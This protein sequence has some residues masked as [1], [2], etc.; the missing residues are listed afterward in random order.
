MN[1]K[2][3]FCLHRDRD[4]K[5]CKNCVSFSVHGSSDNF[6]KD[7]TV[8]T[9]EQRQAQDKV[10]KKHIK[11]LE[12]EVISLKAEVK[13]LEDI[14]ASSEDDEVEEPDHSNEM[15]CIEDSE[16]EEAVIKQ[17]KMRAVQEHLYSY[18]MMMRY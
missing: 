17:D 14:V 1:N 5:Y 10:N 6:L 15:N 9:E 2:C 16:D 8:L 7:N 13:R 12:A 4:S 18:S 3:S 11:E